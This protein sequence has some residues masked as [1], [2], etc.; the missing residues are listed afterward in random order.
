MSVPRAAKPRKTQAKK[1]FCY[2]LE[3]DRKTA[4]W[5]RRVVAN[6][7]QWGG[8]TT[9]GQTVL[10]ALHTIPEP[11]QKERYPHASKLNRRTRR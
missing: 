7:V 5:L 6:W 4:L 1:Y 9:M 8:N 11:G 2:A 10:D 3:M